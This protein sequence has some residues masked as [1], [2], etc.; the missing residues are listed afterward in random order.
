MVVVLLLWLWFAV[1]FMALAI[2]RAAAVGDM[3]S[4]VP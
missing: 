2:C 1:A 4:V 3:V